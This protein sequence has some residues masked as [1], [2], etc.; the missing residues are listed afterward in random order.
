MAE[1]TQNPASS[2]GGALDELAKDDRLRASAS[3]KMLGGAGAVSA[4]SV[5]L[6]AACG[7]DD[8]DKSSSD[9]AKS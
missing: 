8:R 2:S 6:W 7:D 5:A 1:P 4:F 9:A 3:F